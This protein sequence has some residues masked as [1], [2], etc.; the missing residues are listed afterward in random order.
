MLSNKNIVEKSPKTVRKQI[1]HNPSNMNDSTEE[2]LRKIEERKRNEGRSSIFT[3]NPPFT[4]V[5]KS[6]YSPTV[7]DVPAA[8]VDQP[9]PK[10]RVSGGSVEYAPTEMDM[11]ETTDFDIDCAATVVRNCFHFFQFLAKF[12]V[13]FNIHI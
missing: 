11:Q 3:I 7:C 4:E 13:S 8:Y 6:T 5:D 10:D 12:W 1:L 2:L 9:T